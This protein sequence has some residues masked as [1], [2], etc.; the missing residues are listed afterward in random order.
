MSL[1]SRTLKSFLKPPKD[2]HVSKLDDIVFRKELKKTSNVVPLTKFVLNKGDIAKITS[3][4]DEKNT[5]EIDHPVSTS[6]LLSAA[7]DQVDITLPENTSSKQLASKNYDEGNWSSTVISHLLSFANLGIFFPSHSFT[8]SSSSNPLLSFPTT[9][10]APTTP[11]TLFSSYCTPLFNVF[12]RFRSP[13]GNPVNTLGTFQASSSRFAAVRNLPI[14][15][16]QFGYEISDSQYQAV[17]TNDPHKNY[18]R[19]NSEKFNKDKGIISK[20]RNITIEFKD[21][22]TCQFHYNF[23]KREQ[24]KYENRLKYIRDQIQAHGTT[25]M[26]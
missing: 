16:Y 6:K 9:N 15:P 7:S 11:T 10:T 12:T 5:Q 13:H 20:M 8:R 19:L 24:E 26:I 25:E 18:E 1:V 17:F 22:N 4:N 21:V 23:G 14:H 3:N 2:I